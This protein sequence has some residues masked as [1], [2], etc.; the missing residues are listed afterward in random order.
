[1]MTGAQNVATYISA[2]ALPQWRARPSKS[3]RQLIALSLAEWWRARPP[4]SL[5]YPRCA[6]ALQAIP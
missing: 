3:T 6:V 5:R 4:A 2:P 1:M